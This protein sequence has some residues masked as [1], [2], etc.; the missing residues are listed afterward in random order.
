MAKFGT[1]YGK[2]G[3]SGYNHAIL[4]PGDNLVRGKD[5]ND[6]MMEF[7]SGIDIEAGRRQ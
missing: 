6:M 1:M 2:V 5:R 4:G 7:V 3:K